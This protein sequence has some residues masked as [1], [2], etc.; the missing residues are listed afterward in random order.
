[1]RGT[2]KIDTVK[3][4]VLAH[5]VLLIQIGAVISIAVIVAAVMI[6]DIVP[7]K[8]AFTKEVERLDT[9]ITTVGS[10]V[11]GLGSRLV[12]IEAS[13]QATQEEL[14]AATD[15]MATLHTRLDLAN[16][17][18]D[19][20]SAQL[21]A[22]EAMFGSPPEAW[23]TGTAGNYTLHAKA[24]EAGNFTATIHLSYET[25]VEATNGTYQ[26]ALDAFYGSIDWDADNL[27]DY[28]PALSYDGTGWNVIRVSFSVGVFKLEAKTEKAIA[29]LFDGLHEHYAPDW[30]YVEIWP[31]V[32]G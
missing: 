11:S 31:A 27:N 6:H 1:M 23:L 15:A 14:D 21:E 29:V 17:H 4:W 20:L 10:T 26:Q 25:P 24:S 13:A 12:A 18:I 19:T 30:A 32:K 7:T 9:G 5:K 16:E 8:T 2:S 28:V 22:A 3:M